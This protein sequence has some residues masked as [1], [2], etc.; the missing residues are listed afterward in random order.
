MRFC[1]TYE[2]QSRYDAGM[3]KRMN[4]S[5]VNRL[6]HHR[7]KIASERGEL[8]Q[9]KDEIDELLEPTERA[10]D[11]LDDAINAMSEVA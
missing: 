9:I 6:K 10:V 11:A 1:F 4:K 5:L 8:R 7:D 2:T 3:K